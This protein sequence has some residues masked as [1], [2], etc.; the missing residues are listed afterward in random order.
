M[1]YSNCININLKCLKFRIE[2]IDLVI[3][4]ALTL[5]CF[6]RMHTIQ[7]QKLNQIVPTHVA[8]TKTKLLAYTYEY[9]D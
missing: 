9:L 2:F 8:L 3:L 4:F 5:K 6:V 7:Q 1:Y